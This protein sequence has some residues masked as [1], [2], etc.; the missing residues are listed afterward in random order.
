MR[1]IAIIGLG[2]IGGS[3]AKAFCATENTTVFGYDKDEST[4]RHAVLIHAIDSR[5]DLEKLGEIDLIFICLYPEAAEKFLIDNAAKL[6]KGAIVI[7]CCGTKTRICPTGFMLAKQHEFHFVGGHPM[8]GKQF[9]GLKHSRADMFKNANMIIV[10]KK[11]EDLMLLERVKGILVEIG[12]SGITITSAEEHDRIIAYTSQLPH[13]V[14][15][16]FVKSPSSDVHKGF[17]AGSY[18]DLTRVAQLNEQM[19][20]ELFF[21]NKE[22]ITF[23]IKNIIT[24]LQ[25]YVDALEED[26]FDK[27]RSL[28]RDGSER[29]KMLDITK[30]AN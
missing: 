13:V 17:S 16:A 2:L 29:K 6:K 15:N 25:K 8:A 22:N 21:E 7:D 4:V 30:G 3:F 9:S 27:V 20:A 5:L 10:P 11:N 28:L 23:E 12:F 18:R 1:K 26:D 24:E 19:W 14:S